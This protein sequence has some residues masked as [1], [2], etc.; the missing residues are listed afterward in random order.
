MIRRRVPALGRLYGAI[1]VTTSP[2]T[3]PAVNALLAE[4]GVY[5][6]TPRTNA[7]GPLYRLALR[8]A[9]ATGADRVHYLDFDRALHWV[10][11]RPRELAAVLRVAERHPAL[12]IGR[13]I[14]AHRS[15][16]RPLFETER[17]ANARLAARLGLERRVD[18]LV[19]SFALTRSLVTALLRRSRARDA[20]IY[21]EWPALLAT[22]GVPLAYGE[23][24]GLDWET[25]D[26]A[27]AEVRRVGLTAWRHAF[28]T[29]AEWNARRAMAADIARGFRAAA[30]RRPFSLCLSR[31]RIGST[32]DLLRV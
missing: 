28:D 25:P 32:Q 21:G 3:A 5:A 19:P 13:T 8:R 23:C 26:R 9:L 20:S 16:H 11:T 31:L 6:G 12:V 17:A 14:A 18:F 30:G 24:R 15:H 22:L 27:R 1:A 7:R 4:L 10:A 2:P 29:P